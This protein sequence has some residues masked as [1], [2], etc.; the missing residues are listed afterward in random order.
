MDTSNLWTIQA[1]VIT[2]DDDITPDGGWTCSHQVPM[3]YLNGDVQGFIGGPTLAIVRSVLD[4]TKSLKPD[5]EIHFVA[6]NV[7]TGDTV[8]L[9]GKVGP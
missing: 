1:Q 9:G 2:T 7:S 4:P 3:F 6:L 5:A 8:V